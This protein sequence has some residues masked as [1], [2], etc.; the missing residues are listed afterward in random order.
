ML[1]LNTNVASIGAQNNLRGTQKMLDQSISRLS[2]GLRVR[3]SRDDSAGL[4]V[5]ENLRAQLKGYNQ[6]VRNANDGVAM[7]QTAEGSYQAVSDILIRMRELAVQSSSDGLGNT[8]RNYL[9]TEF[10]SLQTEIQRIAQVT[11]Y[12]GIKLTDGTTNG[13]TFQIGTRNTSNDRISLSL[14]AL[15]LSAS[16]L[17]SVNSA[18]SSVATQAG[19]QTSISRIDTALNRINDFRAKLGSVANQLTVSISNLGT[20]IENLSAAES[21][22][23]DADIGQESASF[24]RAAVLQQAGVSMLAQ[25]NAQPNLALRLLG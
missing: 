16:T 3:S 8:E 7:A 23:R 6:A 12:N 2:S 1:S 4:A 22:I 21:Q 17:S 20:T 15:T 13:L 11:E 5:S 14:K 19:A 9:Q 25:A 24:A 18:S 10:K